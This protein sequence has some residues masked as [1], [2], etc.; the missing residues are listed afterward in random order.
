MPVLTCQVAII[1]AGPYGLAAAAYLRSANVETC[2]FGKSMEFWECQM[3][4][5]MFL[6]SAWYACHISDPHRALTLDEYQAAHDMQLSKPVPLDGFIKYGKWFQRQVVPDLDQRRV[7]RI[8]PISKG[9]RLVLDDGESLQAQ[10]VV[11][12]TGI[13]SFAWRPPQFDGLPPTLASHS[14]EHRGLSRFAGQQVI[15]VGGGQSALES[16]ALLHEAGADVEVVVRAPRVR[17]L[18]VGGGKVTRSLPNPLRGPIRRLLYRPTDVGP[19]GL[20][21]IVATPDLFRRLPRVI[22]DR[23]AYR[24][25]GPAGAGW[26]PARLREVRITTGHVI[27]SAAPFRERLRLRLDDGTERYI[28]HVLLATGYRVDASRYSFLAPELVQV[29]RR[30]DGYPKMA[31]GFESPVPGLHFLGA[32]AAGTFGPLMRFVSGTPYTAYTLTRCILGQTPVHMKGGI[33][34]NDG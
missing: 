13:A 5:G 2:V 23:I 33:I 21:L 26:L 20:N 34:Y 1:G 31:A 4:A 8:E 14:S 10:R 25:A 7:V 24:A 30:A 29:V 18:G 28:D 17:W 6:R 19:L 9:F 11:A 22:Q 3:P 16:A 32:P 12:A 15:V 27:T